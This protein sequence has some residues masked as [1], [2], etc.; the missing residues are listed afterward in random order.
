M[1]LPE[2][3]PFLDVFGYLCLSVYLRNR[4]LSPITGLCV[5]QKPFLGKL[6]M[7]RFLVSLLLSL[8]SYTEVVHV[9]KYIL[10]AS[11]CALVVCVCSAGHKK[12]N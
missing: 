6:E 9:L 3:L 2:L 8:S 12:Q 4:F 10:W 1:P 11:E 7:R 5:L